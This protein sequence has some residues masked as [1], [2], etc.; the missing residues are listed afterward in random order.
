[1]ERAKAAAAAARRPPSEP[2]VDWEKLRQRSKLLGG[3][4]GD[5]LNRALA[6]VRTDFEAFQILEREGQLPTIV[7]ELTTGDESGGAGG[8]A[9][10]S[11]AKARLRSFA[12]QDGGA[13]AARKSQLQRREAELRAKQLKLAGSVGQR[14][15]KDGADLFV[16]GAMP[17]ATAVG[18]LAAAAPPPAS[19]TS[20][21]AAA[22][23]AAAAVLTGWW[24]S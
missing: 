5:S 10:E 24:V 11:G 22:A 14:A 2:P 3:D 1:M 6:S 19:R 4:V 20:R 8:A 15:A 13:G 16:Y 9:K 18:R 21:A 17:S 7:E 23:A 12:A